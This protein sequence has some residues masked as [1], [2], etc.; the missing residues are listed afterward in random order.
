MV[1]VQPFLLTLFSLFAFTKA[2]KTDMALYFPMM[3]IQGYAFWRFSETFYP[4]AHLLGLK[5]TTWN[6][7]GLVLTA[8]VIPLSVN[9]TALVGVFISLLIFYLGS[10]KLN[11]PWPWQAMGR[12]MQNGLFPKL[13][14]LG[15]V[16]FVG[17]F[18]AVVGL[19]E[20]V[21]DKL[22]Y[23]TEGFTKLFESSEAVD[24]SSSAI[25]KE[26]LRLL[27]A[28]WNDTLNWVNVLF[29]Y[30][31]AKS[32]ETIFYLSA[33]R[34]TGYAQLVQTVHNSYI[35]FVFDYGMVSLLYFGS[36]IQLFFSHRRHLR[37]L[38]SDATSRLF[39]LTLIATVLYIA[40][41]G[42]MDG[43]RVQMAIQLF[44]LLG[45]VEGYR[46]QTWMP[47]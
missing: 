9:K 17:A 8:L 11:C 21:T 24:F 6:V 41:Y 35:E 25:R 18:I 44:A 5:L 2:G 34:V 23:F 36:I 33:M 12:F 42:S 20:Q 46:S 29:G 1:F 40:I 26:N 15:S 31:L 47:V 45:F 32:R 22:D 30:G 19:G 4:A 43:I 13:L 10:R 37:D 14:V 28:E 7:L 16:V 27:F 3:F 38:K 39:S